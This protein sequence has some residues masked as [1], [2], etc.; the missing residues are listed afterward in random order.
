MNSVSHPIRL[1]FP[2]KHFVIPV[3]TSAPSIYGFKCSFSPYKDKGRG[4]GCNGIK[5][6]SGFISLVLEIQRVLSWEGDEVAYIATK[7]RH[8]LG[9]QAVGVKSPSQHK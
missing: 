2:T 1:T 4:T 6:S 5:Q 9:A 8:L 3:H 7:N